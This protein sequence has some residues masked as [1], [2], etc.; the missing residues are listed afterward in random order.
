VSSSLVLSS[1]HMHVVCQVVDQLAGL[2]WNLEF[3]ENPAVT[4]TVELAKL[5]L[6]TSKDE[7]EEDG[8]KGGTDSSNDTDAT[9]VEDAPS[10]FTAPP[11][12]I[13]QPPSRSS[14][15][16]LGKRS[17]ESTSMMDVDGQEYEKEKD[18]VMVSKPGSPRGE[19]IHSPSGGSATQSDSPPKRQGDSDVVMHDVSK[20]FK[21]VVPSRKS[22][23]SVMMFGAYIV[24]TFCTFQSLTV[25]LT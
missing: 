18:Y 25:H 2:F 13:S 14:P 23:E 5:A 6:V 12:E 17:R 8:D 11:E 7:E 19:D 9:L 4:P 20:S 10:H 15:S 3:C 24:D 16:V 1:I 22:S 21:S